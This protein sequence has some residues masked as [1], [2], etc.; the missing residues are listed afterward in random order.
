MR[1]NLYRFI[2]RFLPDAQADGGALLNSTAPQPD[3]GAP[4]STESG[5]HVGDDVMAWLRRHHLAPASDEGVTDPRREADRA[6]RFER[7]AGHRY[8]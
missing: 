8:Y 3:S 6:L 5:R 1:A 7:A 4:A 2:P